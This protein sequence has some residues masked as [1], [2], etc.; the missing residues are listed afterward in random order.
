MTQTTEQTKQVKIGSADER[1]GIA[2]NFQNA[3]KP[4][5]ATP[6]AVALTTHF[7]LQGDFEKEDWPS[8]ADLAE[9][10]GCTAETIKNGL[11][12]A[13]HLG[14]L[15]LTGR[16]GKSAMISVNL[17]KLP[18]E[19][20]ESVGKITPEAIRLAEEYHEW[21]CRV[22]FN[23][24]GKKKKLNRKRFIKQQSRTAQWMFCHVGEQKTRQIIQFASQHDKFK[25]RTLN[26]LYKLRLCWF[27]LTVA[28]EASKATPV[29]VV[30]ESVPVAPVVVPES[31]EEKISK[32]EREIA[33]YQKLHDDEY[34]PDEKKIRLIKKIK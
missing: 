24:T 2:I 26:S 20:A 12:V 25:N 27:D 6:L 22:Y 34:C 31:R 4:K 3:P 23:R 7:I 29:P 16:T 8:H 11:E 28:F 32:V 15:T 18:K 30:K 14:W 9:N 21:V 10:Y 1:L 5:E 13:E 19:V 17:N 33:K